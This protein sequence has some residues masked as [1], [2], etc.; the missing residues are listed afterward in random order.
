MNQEQKSPL[1]RG[2]SKKT[3]PL[4]KSSLTAVNSGIHRFR[5]PI[6]LAIII[7]GALAV[8][9]LFRLKVSVKIEDFF[10]DGDPILEKQEKFKKLFNT[11][12]SVAVLVESDDIFSRESLEVIHRTGKILKKKIP[13]AQEVISLT[14]LKGPQFAAARLPF[15]NNILDASDTRLK[16]FKKFCMNDR[17][18]K[19]TLFSHD[20]KQ[21][22]IKLKLKPWPGQDQWSDETDP[23]FSTGKAA[24]DAVS[25]IKSSNVTLTA[26][27][28]PVYAYRKEKEM[29]DDLHE[30]LIIG[31]IVAF[32]L[33]LL[34]F[35]TIQ[36]VTGTLLVIAFSVA[37]VFGVQ[38][39]LGVTMDSAFIAV[40]VLLA[41]GVSIGYTVHISRFFS[42]YFRQTGKRRNSVIFAQMKSARPI[43]FTAFTT[44][45]ALLS[46]LSVE[47]K[48]IRWVGLTSALAVMAVFLFS[49]VL[50]PIILAMGKDQAATGKKK[51]VRDPLQNLLHYFAHIVGKHSRAIVILSL[52]A[53]GA[54][55]W[56]SL[57]L[58]VDFNA[59]KMTGTRLPHMKDHIHIGKSEIASVDV[60]HLAITMPR[61]SFKAPENIQRLEK[62]EKDILALP[63][64]KKTRSLAD[65]IG[66][67][68]YYIH[69]RLPG[70]DTI[71]ERENELKGL[72]T[73]L[74]KF[75]SKQIAGWK[76][77]DHTSTRIIIQLKEFSSREIEKTMAKIDGLMTENFPAGTKHF[78]S[79]STCQ[80]ATMNQYITR[81]LLQSVLTALGLITLLMILVFKSIRLGLVAMIPNIFPVLA[82][83]AI[84]GY[85]A[86]PLEFVTMTVAP[87]IMGLAVDDT[88]HLLVHLKEDLATGADFEKSLT[89]TF[90]VVGTAITETTIILCCFFLVF[91][92]SKVNSIITMGIVSCVGI[93]S[94]YLSDIFLTPIIVKRFR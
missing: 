25:S 15:K 37:T 94:A 4:F 92:F 55:I 51:K 20:G 22:W 11:T 72:Y 91:T 19:G 90:S 18:L 66:E 28:V 21:A 77:D 93:L 12:D 88:I 2:G 89:R 17:F 13:L 48:P 43:F 74:E 81:G 23:V 57:N 52:F 10:L 86:I 85:A 5:W 59:E 50:F 24:Y 80:M 26:T 29:M 42:L 41:M 83:G 68:N 36:G 75:N 14:T 9:G 47:I 16:G 73:L 46:F 35:R 54:A 44:I 1:R 6:L 61:E 69:G 40:P 87:M 78:F 67:F 82:A 71:P 38:G 32:L 49:L 62:L 58:T 45:A 70:F 3:S 8:P 60:L 39:W 63:L 7:A 79:G 30:I 84:M 34:I 65:I 53:A 31:A 64:V 27:G 33:S 56:G 76:T